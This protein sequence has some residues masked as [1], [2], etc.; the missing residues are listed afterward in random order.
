M[1]NQSISEDTK[2]D[3]IVS[4]YCFNASAIN[5]SDTVKAETVFWL[6]GVC[7]TSTSIVGIIGN[8]ITIAVLNRISLDNVFNQVRQMTSYDIIFDYIWYY[9]LYL[10]AHCNALRHRFHV[11]GIF[12]YRIRFE[13]RIQIAKLFHADLRQYLAYTGVSIS[14]HHVFLVDFHYIG[15]CNREVC[16]FVDWNWELFDPFS[17]FL[18]YMAICHPFLIQRS[19]AMPST[20]RATN[21]GRSASQ[22][23]VVPLKKRSCYYLLPVILISVIA[24]VPKFLEFETITAM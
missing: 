14:Q 21:R 11:C 1:S 15:Y 6:E 10:T 17:G 2:D 19:Q 13:K 18:R 20:N 5:T 24:N 4:T 16:I 22:Q 7:L 12:T 23:K 9:V 8:S 3:W